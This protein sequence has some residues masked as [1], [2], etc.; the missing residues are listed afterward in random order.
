MLCEKLKHCIVQMVPNEYL[1][2]FIQ[3][4]ESEHVHA[5]RLMLIMWVYESNKYMSA[6]P[7][8]ISFYVHLITPNYEMQL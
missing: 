7:K 3:M 5:G 6:P 4:L 1:N 8:C 2:M